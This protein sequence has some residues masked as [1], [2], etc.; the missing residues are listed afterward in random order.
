M[1][2]LRSGDSGSSCID[3]KC[4]RPLQEL[5]RLS[6]SRV[7]K[8]DR[9]VLD[10]GDDVPI[11]PERSHHV[12]LMRPAELVVK[13]Q[14][15]PEMAEDRYEYGAS[16][17]CDLEVE[18]A[19]ALAEPPAHDDWIYANMPRGSREK[20][21]VRMALK[22][23]DESLKQQI[24][25]EPLQPSGDD[26]KTPLGAVADRLGMLLA[27]EEGPRLTPR[28]TST[29]KHSGGSRTRRSRILGLKSAGLTMLAGQ[30][31]AK[32]N[33]KLEHGDETKGTHLVAIPEVLLAGGSST[34]TPVG[35]APPE[36]VEWILPSGE[37]VRSMST[38]DVPFRESGE[39]QVS[40]SI[41]RDS[42]VTVRVDAQPME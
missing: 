1:R 18:R 9:I 11:V 39:M 28:P 30:M 32:F 37:T 35:V 34:D 2:S 13:Y 14:I 41:P 10:T 25:P 8:K 31:V 17:V 12:A 3:I 15:G 38:I 7:R 23:I 26:S 40:V 5:G 21:F 19:F 6:I 33:F 16:F 24:I 22:R 4:R 42:A 20:T 27:T 29:K 36:I